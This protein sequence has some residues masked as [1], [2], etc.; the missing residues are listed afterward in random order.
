[1][2]AF[3]ALFDGE[4]SDIQSIMATDRPSAPSWFNVCS[5][6]GEVYLEWG[7]PASDGGTTLLG[8]RIYRSMRGESLKLVYHI[9]PTET[10]YHDITLV[11]GTEYRYR[12]HAY[13]LIGNG[14]PS[15]EKEG[16]STGPPL[17]PL[18]L[19]TESGDSQILV[20]WNHPSTDGG[21]IITGYNVYVGRS[22]DDSQLISTVQSMNFVHSELTN[23]ERWY[24]RVSAINQHGE[25]PMSDIVDGV[26]IGPPSPPRELSVVGGLDEVMLTWSEP[27][28]TGGAVLILYRIYRG[29]TPDLMLDIYEVDV[30]QTHFTDYQVDSGTTYFYSVTA[31]NI[32]SESDPSV[33]E[34][35]MPYGVPTSP[36]GLEA[37]VVGEGIHL[38]WVLPEFNGGLDISGYVLRRGS[39]F[40]DVTIIAEG[41]T[42]LSYTD[43]DADY[44]MEYLYSVTAAN[45]AGESEPTSVRIIP[46]WKPS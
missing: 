42:N 45:T 35:V 19:K 20:T 11:N 21:S 32:A 12:I 34:S 36:R 27:D 38:T 39:T 18:G 44:G 9:L 33:A 40:E 30:T 29:E 17:Q 26:S 7:P 46:I 8:Y 22:E 37:N 13:S 3:N 14:Y 23:S 15:E 25:G 4:L 2:L 28:E 5:S 31:V 10:S 6:I 43:T 24:Y 16:M 41:V 1:M